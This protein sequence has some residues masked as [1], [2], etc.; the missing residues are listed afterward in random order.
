M[1]GKRKII[2]RRKHETFT[3]YTHIRRKD[4]LIFTIDFSIEIVKRVILWW[5]RKKKKGHGYKNKIGTYK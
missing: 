1:N 3:A 4:N 2:L 5:M